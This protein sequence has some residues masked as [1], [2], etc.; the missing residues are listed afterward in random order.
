MACRSCTQHKCRTTYKVR[1]VNLIHACDTHIHC[2]C[3]RWHCS[4]VHFQVSAVH[5]I[6]HKPYD[7]KQIMAVIFKVLRRAI[8]PL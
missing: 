2:I 1:R 8:H 4:E 7:R 3:E 5:A 6:L